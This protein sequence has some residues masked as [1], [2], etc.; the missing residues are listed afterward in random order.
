MSANIQEL[1]EK[2][3]EVKSILE[4]KIEKEISGGL[5]IT[6]SSQ[7]GLQLNELL[8]EAIRNE[9]IKAVEDLLKNGAEINQL[10]REQSTSISMTPLHL[11]IKLVAKKQLEKKQENESKGNIEIAESI[12]RLLIEK[13]ADVNIPTTPGHYTP[14]HFAIVGGLRNI[15][16]QL[17]EKGA[18]YLAPTTHGYPAGRVPGLTL[19]REPF[20][21]PPQTVLARPR[22]DNPL[23]QAEVNQWIAEN[24]PKFKAVLP[25]FDAIATRNEETAISLIKA[26]QIKVEKKELTEDVFSVRNCEPDGLLGC[27]F[28]Y[29]LY[30]VVSALLD[31]KVGVNVIHQDEVAPLHWVIQDELGLDIFE[32][33][34]ARKADPNIKVIPI[35]RNFRYL[36]A[37]PL[38]SIILSAF[39]T[40]LIA[41]EK[42]FE[43]L[44][45]YGADFSVCFSN[46]ASTRINYYQ[47]SYPEA[48]ECFR[49]FAK[50][51][52][53][54]PRGLHFGYNPQPANLKTI[55]EDADSLEN[56]CNLRIDSITLAK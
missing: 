55:S 29:G 52:N 41:L 34:L 36:E 11:A 18:N 49:K 7:K 25:L 4:N 32:R 23:S 44:S 17:I 16:R 6:G 33:L 35:D 40:D 56:C 8:I 13:G 20:Y 5:L 1:K 28:R 45:Q 22:G 15:T 27:A 19:T 54:F 39:K 24:N 47:H 10:L 21:L 26:I 37:T 12:V 30:K 48:F 38:I 53:P 43:L 14:L 51:A 9:D 31:V 3:I 2:E 42:H 50:L 46:E